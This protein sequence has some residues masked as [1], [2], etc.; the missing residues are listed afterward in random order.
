M[1]RA[2]AFRIG[3]RRRLHKP[4]ADFILSGPKFFAGLSFRKAALSPSG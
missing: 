3:A 2:G 4:G 1:S